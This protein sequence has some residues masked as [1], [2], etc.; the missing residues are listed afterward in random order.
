MS[1]PD[2]LSLT[3]RSGESDDLEPP[4]EEKR[5]ESKQRLSRQRKRQAKKEGSKRIA[6]IDEEDDEEATSDLKAT[7]SSGSST[8]KASVVP[9]QHKADGRV[10][11]VSRYDMA[12]E[13]RE[14]FVVGYDDYLDYI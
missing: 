12:E 4:Q 8:A 2:L 5:R 9:S 13:K 3:A 1:P 10:V 14:G 6:S 7:P 11:E